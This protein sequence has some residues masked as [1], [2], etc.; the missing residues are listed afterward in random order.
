MTG[1][2]VV[3]SSQGVV[4]VEPPDALAGDEGLAVFADTLSQLS[5]PV[6]ADNR[7]TIEVT[8]SDDVP[9]QWRRYTEGYRPPTRQVLADLPTPAHIT[10]REGDGAGA[11]HWR[12]GGFVHGRWGTDR[13]Q[14]V[15]SPDAADL[16]WLLRFLMA[17]PP[18]LWGAIDVAHSCLVEWGGRS[19]LLAGPSHS[20][21]S[22]LSIL[23]ALNGGV[24]RT[25]DVTYA[26]A[27]GRVAPVSTRTVMT[28][29][30][31][32]LRAFAPRLRQVLGEHAV[33]ALAASVPSRFDL[34]PFMDDNCRTVRPVDAIVF[35]RI[36]PDATEVRATPIDDPVRVNQRCFARDFPSVV[37]WLGVFMS[38][39]WTYV[40]RGDL[41]HHAPAYD[42]ALPLSYPHRFPEIVAALRL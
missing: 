37:E 38:T 6:R 40:S 2:L 35:P 22:S 1:P 21:K 39:E 33:A 17:T 27:D 31:G 36:T 19:V 25:E 23:F 7:L 15:T 10:V 41:G 24:I 13:I 30:E 9:G 18:V 42:L 20:G 14:L 12:D 34:S 29:R 32:T 26:S 28:M 3:A 11:I 16:G 4:A 5:G 8:L